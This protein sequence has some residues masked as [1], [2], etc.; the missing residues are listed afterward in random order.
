ME[1]EIF[2]DLDTGEKQEFLQMFT[3][4][5]INKDDLIRSEGEKYKS[6]FYLLSGKIAVIKNSSSE[7]IEVIEATKDDDIFF[8]FS[9][10]IDSGMS[11][12][13]IK[14]KTSCTIAEISDKEFFEFC[15]KNP[16]IGV[17][18]MQRSMNMLMRFLRNSDKKLTEMYKTLEEVL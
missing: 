1:K 6:G 16:Q 10:L 18:I 3:N 17:K 4:R 8:S 14:A 12:T 15:Q 11:L 2:N 5:E 9:S 13:T 7:D